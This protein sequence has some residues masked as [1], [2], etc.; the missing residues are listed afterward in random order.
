[1]SELWSS[2]VLVL[3]T[4]IGSKGSNAWLDFFISGSSSGIAT[5]NGSDCP[6][7]CNVKFWR[8]RIS[9][10]FGWCQLG[11]NLVELLFLHFLCV[12]SPLKVVF[13]FAVPH[14]LSVTTSAQN[15]TQLGVVVMLDNLTFAFNIIEA[16]MD[17]G[18]NL[19]S[20]SA[21]II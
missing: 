5:F 13:G 12:L 9:I 11:Q 6:D 19:V 4:G 14:L 10:Q 17:G 8:V 18:A 16:F 2:G 7:G 1:M 15:L 3:P 21:V 20:Q